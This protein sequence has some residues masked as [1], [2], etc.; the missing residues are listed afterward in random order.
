L[1][2]FA[3]IQKSVPEWAGVVNASLAEGAL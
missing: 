2:T 3:R 1:A